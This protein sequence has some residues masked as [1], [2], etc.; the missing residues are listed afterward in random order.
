[1]DAARERSEASGGAGARLG[2][3]RRAGAVETLS[4]ARDKIEVLQPLHMDIPPTGLAHGRTALRLESVNGGYDPA[5]LAIL[6]LSLT[7][8][9][10]ERIALCGPNGS[11]KTTLLKIITGQLAPQCGRVEV[12][13]PFAFLDQ[14]VGSL[15]PAR[16]LREN[17][18]YLN[19]G[20]DTQMTY[21]ALARFGFRSADALRRAGALSGGERLRAG[22]ACVLGALP[23]PMLLILDEPTNHLDLDGLAALEAALTAYDGAVIVVSHDTAFLASLAPDRT[24]HLGE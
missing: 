5:R 18:L 16:T 10:P 8:T 7:V 1:M 14:H 22:L 20:V 6:D 21:S 2:D 15:D 13:V 11:G 3:A 9:G 12:S 23:P 4:A 24:I 19:P 17:F